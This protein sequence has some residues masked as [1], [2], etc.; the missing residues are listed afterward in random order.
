MQKSQTIRGLP[1]AVNAKVVMRVIVNCKL[2]VRYLLF[3]CFA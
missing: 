3:L 1:A 2:M